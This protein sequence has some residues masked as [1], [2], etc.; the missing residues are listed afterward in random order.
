MLK[1]L[2]GGFQPLCKP[3]LE[4]QGR[5]GRRS[6]A[7]R[8]VYVRTALPRTPCLRILARDHTL[9]HGFARDFLYA[10][11]EETRLPQFILSL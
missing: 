9:R 8:K 7:S 5:L 11:Q 10:T 3:P 6:D 1:C 2:Q 4:S